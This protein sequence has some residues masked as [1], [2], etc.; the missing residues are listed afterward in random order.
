MG[1]SYGKAVWMKFVF[2]K[3]LARVARSKG[4][5]WFAGNSILPLM[6]NYPAPLSRIRRLAFTLVAAKA[7]KAVIHSKR[8]GALT[9]R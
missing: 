2:D 7:E 6:I 4:A 5:Y 9:E 1:K 3:I 8:S